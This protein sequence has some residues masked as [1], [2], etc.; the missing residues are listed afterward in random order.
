MC[1]RRTF[2]GDAARVKDEA[3]E[4]QDVAVVGDDAGDDGDAGLDGEV[5]RA[6]LEGQQ[7][8]LLCVAAGALGE[9][10]DALA[11]G[12]NLLG[13]ALHGLAGVL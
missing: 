3:L 10:V 4:V 7:S 11:L 12:A 1:R 6:L 8:G 13:G 9:H 2:D 5:K